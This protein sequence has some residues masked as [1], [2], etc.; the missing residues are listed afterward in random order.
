VVPKLFV[1]SLHAACNIDAL[2]SHGISHVLNIS[3][4]RRAQ[5]SSA[6]NY[7]SIDLRDKDYSNLL[8]CIPAANIFIHAGLSRGGVL[9]H[10]RGGKSRSPALVVAYLMSHRGWNLETSLEA[11]A[12]AR[13]LMAINRGFAMQLTMYERCGFDVYQAQQALLRRRTRQMADA[14]SSTTVKSPRRSTLS[15]IRV[16]ARLR[17]SCAGS[18]SVQ[19]IPPLRGMDLECVC[20]SC[21]AMLFISSS[22]FSHSGGSEA[23][24]DAAPND[25]TPGAARRG[26][27]TLGR[28]S[29]GG[30]DGADSASASSAA[31]EGDNGS[32][33]VP[34]L[35]APVLLG[36]IAAIASG[37][38]PAGSIDDAFGVRGRGGATKIAAVSRQEAAKAAVAGTASDGADFQFDDSVDWA[39]ESVDAGGAL[40]RAL[41]A[42]AQEEGAR[43]DWAVSDNGGPR[44]SV[45][46]PPTGPAG[47]NRCP[48]TRAGD[49]VGR[50]RESGG[51]GGIGADGG[52]GFSG[53]GFGGGG[54]GGGGFGG[55]GFGGGGFGSDGDDVVS[56]VLVPSPKH[57][58][59]VGLLPFRRRRLGGA[60]A[61][62]WHP[63]VS[64]SPATPSARK[65][66][67]QRSR[68]FGFAA[69][70]GCAQEGATLSGKDRASSADP[71]SAAGDA[72]ERR[73]GALLGQTDARSP[74]ESVKQS[75]G[76][77]SR[78]DV[79]LQASEHTALS[80]PAPRKTPE[81]S[82]APF[83]ASDVPAG[84]G[85]AAAAMR[86]RALKA[87]GPAR[88]TP[89]DRFAPT[90]R[91]GGC[92]GGRRGS[93]DRRAPPDAL[94]PFGADPLP[95]T[96]ALSAAA[97]AEAAAAAAGSPRSPR[98][99]RASAFG[100]PG[101][102]EQQRWVTRMLA[103]ELSG[104]WKKKG[105]MTSSVAVA[106]LDASAHACD[107]CCIEPMAWMGGLEEDRGTLRCP[108]ADCAVDIGFW[109]W[110]GRRC[111]CGAFVRP[112]FFVEKEAV[113]TRERPM[114]ELEE[115][116][117]RRRR[118]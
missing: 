49:E 54:F 38:P 81:V 3:G 76:D 12:T 5:Y 50:P 10:C 105:A 46:W 91:D 89:A 26:D 61:S 53:D 19:V 39:E 72:N 111:S 106:D 92:S 94:E 37:P 15:E 45:A 66:R 118:R 116:G 65:R 29:G 114:E 73:S 28:T 17:L 85:A 77:A 59:G 70:R 86:R 79:G 110:E 56:G 44:S 48:R 16:P 95:I 52:D 4:E 8:S 108:N 75:V 7:L 98:L 34:I 35:A 58:A 71:L 96:C 6:F 1:G 78:A 113:L 101:S 63:S 40:S 22:V 27:G 60:Q 57:G 117:H 47:S 90:S 14:R 69:A 43:R 51:E 42:I 13:P 55:G 68:G 103:L 97:A 32:Q 36:R 100:R 99:L 84:S 23:A 109:D 115:M 18:R 64:G 11:M 30:S 82:C 21:G 102:S 25:R 67:R 83:S 107:H 112:A 74:D 62:G 93:E 41:A 9:V 80:C 33:A 88:G 87:D 20:R 2:K 104:D 31:A 24:G